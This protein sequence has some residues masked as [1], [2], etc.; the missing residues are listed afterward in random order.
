[1]DSLAN[2]CTPN[3]DFD[4]RLF[5]RACASPRFYTAKTLNRHTSRRI[6][7]AIQ[8]E[9]TTKAWTPRFILITR[10]LP[11]GDAHVA[12]DGS[13][14]VAAVDH[15]IMSLGFAGDSGSDCILEVIVALGMAQGRSEVGGVLLAQ[16]HEERSGAG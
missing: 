7:A 8:A 15:E 3:G 6:C 11:A 10:K 1:M 13:A 4:E 14:P 9:N 16:A 5:Y 12:V 2:F